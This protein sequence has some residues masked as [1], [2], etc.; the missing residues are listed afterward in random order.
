MTPFFP[1]K[2]ETLFETRLYESPPQAILAVILDTPA[3][4]K[5]LLVLGHN[6]GLQALALTLIGSGDTQAREE[7]AAKFPTTALAV[8]DFAAGPWSA[9]RPGTGRL[10]RFV[11]PRDLN[12]DDD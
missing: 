5:S 2:P 3:T 1:R 7:L 6:P 4:I 10:E 12:G 8:I 11:R 9:M